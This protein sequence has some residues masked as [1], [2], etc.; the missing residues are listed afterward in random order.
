MS[1]VP[2]FEITS[3]VPLF[4]IMSTVPLFEIISTVPLFEIMSTVP[5]FSPCL[6]LL[7]AVLLNTGKFLEVE[8]GELCW[9]F[10]ESAGN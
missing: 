9:D 5:L 10:R 8:L 1:T 6:S 4:E 2:L 3:T 7:V